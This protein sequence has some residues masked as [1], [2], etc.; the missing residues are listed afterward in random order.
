MVPVPTTAGSRVDIN[1][2]IRPGVWGGGGGSGVAR[3][4]TTIRR[5]PAGTTVATRTDDVNFVSSNN[6]IKTLNNTSTAD[7]RGNYVY[8]GIE[9]DGTAPEDT[10]AVSCTVMAVEIITY[11]GLISA[12]LS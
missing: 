1:H 10:L 5:G 11:E 3:I 4:V 12:R 2:L 7:F 8:A 9:R 6:A